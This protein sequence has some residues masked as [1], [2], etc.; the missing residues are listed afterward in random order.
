MLAP[1][2]RIPLIATALT[3]IKRTLIRFAGLFGG[4]VVGALLCSIP[5]H[6]RLKYQIDLPLVSVSVILIALSSLAGTMKPRYFMYYFLC[7]LLWLLSDADAPDA[8]PGGSNSESFTAFLYQAAYLAGMPL[9]VIGA[10]L[11]LSSLL[12]T[13]ILG[14]AIFSIGIV[15]EKQ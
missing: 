4:L 12:A 8:H 14:V 15:K 7:P 10:L 5:L 11:S 3:A 2:K 6:L 9:L 13:G 1:K